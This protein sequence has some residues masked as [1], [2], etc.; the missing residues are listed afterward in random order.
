MT[1]EPRRLGGRY[2]LGDLLGRGGM[3]EVRRAK[4]VR[5]DRDVAVKLL[6]VD[7]ATDSTFQARFR[8]E[9]PLLRTGRKNRGGPGRRRFCAR[10]VRKTAPRPQIDDGSKSW[11]GWWWGK[12]DSNLRRHSQRIYSP[13]PL[14]LGTFPRLRP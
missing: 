13:P 6:R 5:L 7:L 9:A 2:E 8:K 3:A 10:S 11:K 14:P 1:D 4:D 12:Q